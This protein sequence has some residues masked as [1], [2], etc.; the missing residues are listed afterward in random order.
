[1]KERRPPLPARTNVAAARV[2][3]FDT[4]ICVG[5]YLVGKLFFS[6]FSGD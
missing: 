1:M 4:D 2:G 5:D 6:F 3:D